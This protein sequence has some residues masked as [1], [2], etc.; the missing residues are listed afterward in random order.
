MLLLKKCVVIAKSFAGMAWFVSFVKNQ[1]TN[2][3]RANALGLQ[4]EIIFHPFSRFQLQWT[5]A[6]V[7]PEADFDPD[8]DVDPYFRLPP[9]SR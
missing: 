4:S 2:N 9:T 8:A 5:D 6:D 1:N 7:D 3:A